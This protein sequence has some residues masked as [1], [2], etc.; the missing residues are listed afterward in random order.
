MLEQ[1]DLFQKTATQAL[2]LTYC[3][4]CLICITLHFSSLFFIHLT[5][6]QPEIPLPRLPLHNFHY[7]LN[8]TLGK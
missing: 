2:S 7:V 8:L 4:N 5:A 6:E 1:F 3:N